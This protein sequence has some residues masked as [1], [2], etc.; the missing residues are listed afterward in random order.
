MGGAGLPTG[1]GGASLSWPGTAGNAAG[2]TASAGT[3]PYVN[4][5]PVGNTA[6]T[7]ATASSLNATVIQSAGPSN[8]TTHD[9]SGTIASGGTAQ[10]AFTAQTTLH[11]FTIANIDATSGSGEVMWMSFTGTAVAASPASYPLPAPTATTY[12]GM[13]SYTTP[14][15]FG[16]GHAVSVI[17]TTTSHQY[18]CTWW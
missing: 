18:S 14:P 13:G 1:V 8:V 5:Y 3:M 9:C 4:S 7:Q 12:V 15:G 2:G 6:V 16:T 10:N 11:G 17:A